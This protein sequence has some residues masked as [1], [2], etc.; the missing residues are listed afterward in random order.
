MN[1]PKFIFRES[2]FEVNSFPT[3]T[4]SIS[5]VN[6]L[7]VVKMARLLKR[8]V[9]IVERNQVF[10]RR[11]VEKDRSGVHDVTGLMIVS[12]KTVSTFGI[13]DRLLEC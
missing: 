9:V 11:A 8:L 5:S 2:C 13:S 6:C 12:L 1:F 4:K 3:E 7:C 10:K